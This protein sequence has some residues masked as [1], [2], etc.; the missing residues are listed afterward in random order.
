[1][2][3]RKTTQG[4]VFRQRGAKVKK[5]MIEHMKKEVIDETCFQQ[6]NFWKPSLRRKIFVV[7]LGNSMRLKDDKLKTV[8]ALYRIFGNFRFQSEVQNH[9]AQSR[10]P[11]R[12]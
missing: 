5:S 9:I 7:P 4:D 2:F 12:A 11:L 10:S 3:L 8:F 1:M 6:N